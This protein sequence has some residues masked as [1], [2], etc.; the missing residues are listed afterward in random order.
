M[1][2]KFDGIDSIADKLELFGNKTT[3]VM[4][5]ALYEGA[6]VM[7]DEMKKNLQSIP[8]QG[9]FWPYVH[10]GSNL[11]TGMTREQKADVINSMGITRM[12]A[13]SDGVRVRIGFNGYT[14]KG[15]GTGQVA[16]PLLVRAFESG[17]SFIRKTPIVRKAFAS[18][19]PKVKEAI[20]TQINRIIS[21]EFSK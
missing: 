15:D 1:K 20:E 5:S 21:E 12:M 9:Q 10:K 4:K 8:V 18:G 17:T 6:R 16:I 19:R 2:L 13:D 14:T 7:A 11:I 3:G